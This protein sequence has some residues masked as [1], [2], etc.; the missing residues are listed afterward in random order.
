MDEGIEG[1][2]IFCCLIFVVVVVAIFT[3]V[4]HHTKEKIWR[5]VATIAPWL[6]VLGFGIRL[7]SASSLTL[8]GTL[9]NLRFSFLSRKMRAMKHTS[10][11][12]ALP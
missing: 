8:P 3:M 10:Q 11:G 9:F 1:R 4:T 5:V 7:W 12:C 2:R 6:R